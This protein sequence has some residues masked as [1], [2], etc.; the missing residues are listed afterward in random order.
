MGFQ[1][2]AHTPHY[3]LH[4]CG[5]SDSQCPQSQNHC[6][7]QWDRRP[8]SAPLH[9]GFGCISDLHPGVTCFALALQVCDCRCAHGT[10]RAQGCSPPPAHLRSIFGPLESSGRLRTASYCLH[11][12]WLL[13]W[14]LGL[15]SRSSV[16]IEAL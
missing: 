5:R 2:L 7:P 15:G 13:A 6:L 8:C 12:S 1:G 10:G 16:W 9:C 11:K 14:W 4:T 3:C